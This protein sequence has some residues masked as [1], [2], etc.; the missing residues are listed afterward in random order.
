MRGRG[1]RFLSL[2]NFPPSVGSR[3]FA[4]NDD[5]LIAGRSTADRAKGRTVK[6]PTPRTFLLI[7]PLIYKPVAKVAG[8]TAKRIPGVSTL[9]I[10]G[11][12]AA[13][14]FPRLITPALL[15]FARMKAV[16]KKII[17]KSSI[18]P[19]GAQRRRHP[20][21]LPLSHAAYCRPRVSR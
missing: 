6:F 3:K 21:P 8:I 12:V 7:F 14:I 10:V 15:V 17:T 18:P 9:R 20:P 1:R 13:R 19:R 16:K 2:R 4:A 5:V 11:F